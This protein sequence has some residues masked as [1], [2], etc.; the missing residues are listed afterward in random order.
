MCISIGSYALCSFPMSMLHYRTTHGFSEPNYKITEVF[1]GSIENS[2]ICIRSSDIIH[3][4][5]IICE[6]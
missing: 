1:S 4:R 5:I 6:L 3:E 2:C